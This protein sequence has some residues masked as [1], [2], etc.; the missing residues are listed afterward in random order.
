M[1]RLI[2]LL[3]IFIFSF[4]LH[5][6]VGSRISISNNGYC[7]IVVAISPNVEQD[8]AGDLLKNIQVSFQIIC[9]NSNIIFTH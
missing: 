4:Q 8:Q 9:I 7:D 5:P 6:S 1:T 3:S 2:T